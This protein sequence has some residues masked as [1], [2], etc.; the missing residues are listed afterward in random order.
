MTADVTYARYCDLDRILA[1]QHPQSN[2]PERLSVR[3]AL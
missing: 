3:T 1:A 2:L